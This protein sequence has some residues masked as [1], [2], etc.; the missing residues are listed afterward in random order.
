ME[1]YQKDQECSTQQ[2]V[3]CTSNDMKCGGD[4]GC[5]GA[6]AE[7]AMDYVARN[8]CVTDG[9]YAYSGRDD[10]C[11]AKLVD[12]GSTTTFVEGKASGGM[13]IGMT[14]WRRL[15]PNKLGPFMDALVNSGPI[16]ASVATY[17]NWNSYFSGILDTCADADRP[18]SEFIVNHAVMLVGYGSSRRDKYWLIQN[19]WGT[20]W[21][22]AGF[23]RVKRLDD[24]EEAETC[25][26]DKEP[27]VGTGC[28]G[29]PKKVWV[30][31]SCGILYD[32]VVPTF[33]LAETG[34]WHT[35]GKKPTSGIQKP[36]K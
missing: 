4:G 28:L 2:I 14:G 16:A 26:W 10:R 30:C 18:G 32:N 11:P 25:A 36:K 3:S 35:V 22:E 29:G 31:G 13:A 7:I 8:G 12:K 33:D 17:D 23:I 24:K 9:S 15:P 19:S 21:G 20:D 1:L 34:W 6:T 5:Q 27:E